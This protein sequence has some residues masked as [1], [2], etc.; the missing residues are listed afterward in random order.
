[1]HD[2]DNK[3]QTY[4]KRRRDGGVVASG[5]PDHTL[6]NV[7][8]ESSLRGWR[9]HKTVNHSDHRYITFEINTIPLQISQ[10]R[11]NTKL[12]S[13]SK[14]DKLIKQAKNQLKT[15]LNTINNAEDLDNFTKLIIDTITSS[16]KKCFRYKTIRKQRKFTFWTPQL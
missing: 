11:F 15:K 5:F 7:L 14:F 3:T 16:A 10:K 2:I 6:S 8:A 12:G 1:M 13:Y 4:V 9:V